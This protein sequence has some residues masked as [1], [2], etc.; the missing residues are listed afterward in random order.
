MLNIDL[1]ALHGQFFLF[2]DERIR[3]TRK[4]V[5]NLMRTVE[6]WPNRLVTYHGFWHKSLNEGQ[7]NKTISKSPNFTMFGTFESNFSV[8]LKNV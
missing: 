3:F 8:I 6:E 1:D 7:A 5:R 2:L 4:E